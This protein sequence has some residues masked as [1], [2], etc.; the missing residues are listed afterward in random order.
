MLKRSYISLFGTLSTAKFRPISVHEAARTSLA[1]NRM[2]LITRIPT[3]VFHFDS[4]RRWT[5]RTYLDYS[6]FPSKS[7]RRRLQD[8][9]AGERSNCIFPIWRIPTGSGGPRHFSKQHRRAYWL[10]K[11]RVSQP[12]FPKKGAVIISQPA[13]NLMQTH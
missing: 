6:P 5:Y 13:I 3:A 7:R 1:F 2:A 9:K 4:Q 8:N 10:A 12:L 11:W